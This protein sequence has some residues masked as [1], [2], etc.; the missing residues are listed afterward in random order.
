MKSSTAHMMIKALTLG[1]LSETYLAPLSSPV[2]HSHGQSSPR[3]LT[4]R[5]VLWNATAALRRVS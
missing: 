5:V 4:H 1:G 2:C 3:I